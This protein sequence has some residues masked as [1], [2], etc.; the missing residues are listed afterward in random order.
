MGKKKKKWSKKFMSRFD[1]K[2]ADIYAL[3]ETFDRLL[4]VYKG[5]DIGDVRAIIDRMTDD[6][7]RNRPKIE[8]VISKLESVLSDARRPR[9][10][11]WIDTSTE[12]EQSSSSSSASAESIKKSWCCF[13]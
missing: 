6:F 2:A 12:S 1:W 4:T 7:V 10:R 3:G 8:G 9:K 13:T 5:E 11:R